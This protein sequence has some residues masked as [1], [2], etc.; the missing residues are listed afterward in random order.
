MLTFSPIPT[1]L[2]DDL[3]NPGIVD[4]QTLMAGIGFSPQESLLA[5]C[6]CSHPPAISTVSFVDSQ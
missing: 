5:H 1:E 6:E 2:C 4:S 3:R